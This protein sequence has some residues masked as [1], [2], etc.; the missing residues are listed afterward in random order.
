MYRKV[1]FAPPVTVAALKQHSMAIHIIVNKS[2]V[3]FGGVWLV[4]DSGALLLLF[5]QAFSSVTTTVH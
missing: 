4:R 3:L 5:I 1:T 2:F